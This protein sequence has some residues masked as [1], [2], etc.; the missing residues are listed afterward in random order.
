MSQ[1]SQIGIFTCIITATMKETIEINTSTVS[2]PTVLTYIRGPTGW[3][4]ISKTSVW[5]QNN[6]FQYYTLEY[7]TALY[8]Q[9]NQCMRHKCTN[10]IVTAQTILLISA[11]HCN[12]ERGSSGKAHRIYR[13][14]IHYCRYL[15]KCVA[16]REWSYL[17]I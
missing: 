11:C 13:Y 17:N 15:E 6:Y 16:Y 10:K 5:H 7:C 1:M 9:Y 14:L 4:K 12:N 2:H 3:L 8:T